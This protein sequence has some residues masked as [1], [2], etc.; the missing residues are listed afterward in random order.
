MFL[1]DVDIHIIQCCFLSHMMGS[2]EV[3]SISNLRRRQIWSYIKQRS[4]LFQ[5]FGPSWPTQPRKR[6]DLLITERDYPDPK[7][8]LDGKDKQFKLTF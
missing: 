3:Y 1:G 8:F 7:R 4:E 5:V 6:G 2:N